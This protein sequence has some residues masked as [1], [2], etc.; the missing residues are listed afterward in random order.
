VDN[1]V[2][3]TVGGDWKLAWQRQITVCPVSD[4]P[5]GAVTGAGPY[6]V[7]NGLD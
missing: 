3:R 5:P 4:L 1:D 6:A 7:G 2:L